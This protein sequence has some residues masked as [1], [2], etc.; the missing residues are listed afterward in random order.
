VTADFEGSASGRASHLSS[1]FGVVPPDA[2]CHRAPGPQMRAHKCHGKSAASPG[3]RAGGK[4]AVTT[5]WARD[6]SCPLTTNY[7]APSIACGTFQFR[8][9]ISP[10]QTVYSAVVAFDG[11]SAARSIAPNYLLNASH[12]PVVD[13]GERRMPGRY[14][15]RSALGLGRSRERAR[16]LGMPFIVNDTPPSGPLEARPSH[17]GLQEAAS[18]SVQSASPC[19]LNHA[20]PWSE[21][22]RHLTPPGPAWHFRGEPENVKYLNASPRRDLPRPDNAPCASR[23]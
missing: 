11:Q 16:R 14:C 4:L 13:K 15:R 19:A 23:R 5:R 2:N 3:H 1:S 12:T 20:A 17:P 22:R 9:L 18:P 21:S 10:G 8:G 7:V 6:K